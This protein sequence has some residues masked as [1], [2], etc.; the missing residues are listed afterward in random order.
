MEFKFFFNNSLLSFWQRLSNI[1]VDSSID[2]LERKKLIIVNQ[3]A[4]INILLLILAPTWA[5][6]QAVHI[7]GEQG[8]VMLFSLLLFISIIIFNYFR[9]HQTSLF[10]LS[11]LPPIIALISSILLKTYAREVEPVDFFYP[12]FMILGFGLVMLV[13]LMYSSKTLFWISYGIHLLVLLSFETWHQLAGVSY[14]DLLPPPYEHLF[15]INF[16]S[17]SVLSLLVAILEMLH[18]TQKQYEKMLQEKNKRTKAQERILER[19]VAVVSKQKK[20]IAAFKQDQARHRAIQENILRITSDYIYEMY[21]DEEGNC[22][23]STLSE[24]FTTHSGYSLEEISQFIRDKSFQHVHPDDRCKMAQHIRHLPQKTQASTDYRILSKEGNIFW[25]R[26]AYVTFYVSEEKSARQVIGSLKDI[27][28]LKAREAAIQYQASLIENVSDAIFST[29]EHFCIVTWNKAAEEL[30]GWKKEEAINQNVSILLKNQYINPPPINITEEIRLRGVW[31]GELQQTRKDGEII[32]TLASISM[33]YDAN[34]RS[35]GL[36]SVHKNIT[37]RKLNEEN[38]RKLNEVLEQ[39]VQDRTRELEQREKLYRLLSENAQDLICLQNYEGRFLYVSPSVKDLLGYTPEELQS[40][41]LQDFVPQHY[42]AQIA[43]L[44]NTKSHSKA[45]YEIYRKDGTL[46]WVETLAKEILI[47]ANASQNLQ[48]QTVTRDITSRKQAEKE[49]E[50]LLQ[51]E[52]ELGEFRSRFISMA[53]H[54]FRT[55][56]TALQSNVELLDF[57]LENVEDEQLFAKIDPIKMRLN[58]QIQRLNEIIEDILILGKLN[59]TQTPLFLKEIN[60]ITF[61]EEILNGFKQPDRIRLHS[62]G[63]ARTI[64]ID[65]NLMQHVISNLLSNALKYSEQDV[66]LELHFSDKQFSISI[67]DKGIGIPEEEQKSL[68]QPFFRASNAIAYDG[69]GLGLIVVKEFV[70][71]HQGEIRMRSREGEGTSFQIIMPVN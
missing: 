3:I 66:T 50:K 18:S 46:I 42:Q 21:L 33:V 5:T 7:S 2:F 54:Q 12:R 69:Y 17:I 13:M 20:S 48:F 62:E 27:N 24:K 15:V 36:V 60:M 63:K 51:K 31:K 39:R 26:D 28:T 10:V 65:P 52:K 37:E 40:K 29:D 9:K 30:Y 45:A 70:E 35:V 59:A 44:F 14:R 34:Q 38:I 61:C 22:Q 47:E 56:L 57:H 4:L 49:S 16:I 64:S 53:S 19:Q 1:G 41:R 6:L 55:P 71:L 58:K 43:Q 8:L 68:F 11:S 32:Y 67:H 23:I 25:V